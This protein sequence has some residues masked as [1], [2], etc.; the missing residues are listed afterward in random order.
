MRTV[1]QTEVFE[2]MSWSRR[3]EVTGGCKQLHN[4]GLH[5]L[6][7]SSNIRMIKIMEDLM[8]KKCGTHGEK[9]H[10]KFWLENVKVRDHL[11]DPDV[12]GR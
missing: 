5:N 2:N 12:E 11:E 3:D 1:T 4:E 6:H 9:V 8:D 7:P 10:T